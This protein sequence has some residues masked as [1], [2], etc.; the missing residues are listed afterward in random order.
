MRFRVALFIL[1]CSSLSSG[2]ASKAVPAFAPDPASVQR[3]GPG[4]RYP[5]AGWIV[6]H[7]EGK[8]YERGVQHGRLL[9]PEIA[10]YIRCF[11]A[12]QS[13]KSPADAWKAVRTLVNALFLRK[14]D[15]EYLEEMQGIADGAAAV[16]AKFE[17]R[18]IDLVDIVAVNTWAEVESLESAL[19]ATPN[20]LEGL[21]I[22]KAHSK[23]ASAEHCSAFAATGPATADGKVVFGHIT[24]F[25]LYPSRFYNVWL[26]IKPEKGHRVVM[27]SYPGGIQSGMD[28]YLNDA[29]LIV[30]ETTIDQ[31][32][33]DAQG[34]PLTSRIRK[35]MQYSD[36]IDKVV[37]TLKT[38]NNGLYSNEWLLADIKTNEIAMFELGTEKTKLWRSSKNEW[39][40]NTPGFYWGCNNGKDLHVRLETIKDLQGKPEDAVWAPS[41][42]D[43]TWMKFYQQYKGK[44]S[45]D[46]GRVAFT[47][48]PLCACTS[49]DAKITT[50]ALAGELKTLA[51]FGPPLG[52]PWLPTDTEKHDYPEVVPLIA[53]PWTLL[54][55]KSPPEPEKGFHIV[56]LPEKV[57][58]WQSLEDRLPAEHE[59]SSKPAWHG[60]IVPKTD[61]DTWLASAFA[62][63]EKIVAAEHAYLE[64][65]GD[66]KLLTSQKQHLTLM[67][68]GQRCAATQSFLLKPGAEK[69]FLE[70]DA[71]VRGET[72]KGVMKLS[73]LREFIGHKKFDEAMDSFG[74]KHGGKMVS[75]AEFKK[76]LE[77]ASG[78]DLTARF[79]LWDSAK[80]TPNLALKAT[81]KPG[82]PNTDGGMLGAV[83]P[84]F[85]VQGAISELPEEKSGLFPYPLEIVTKY[86]GSGT[87]APNSIIP[88][89]EGAFHT[90]QLQVLAE[91]LIGCPYEP[92][93]WGSQT[94]VHV[95]SFYHDLEDCLIVYG[96]L[97]DENTNKETAELLQE[98]IRKR[99]SNITVPIVADITVK[100]EHLRGHHLLLVG[101]PSTNQ[102]AK[103]MEKSFPVSFKSGSFT[104]DG[105]TYANS[106]SAAIASACNPGDKRYSMVMLAGLSSE[107]VYHTPAFLL[108]KGGHPGQLLVIPHSGKA[109]S[110]VIPPS[111]LRVDLSALPIEKK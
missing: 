33:F 80:T 69:D 61:E 73:L 50:A 83:M 71:W 32:R 4:W 103:E 18:A 36:S 74:K 34:T 45:A 44:I 90:T 70:R 42:R 104:V 87:L 94:D 39:F 14:F 51:M 9:A 19:T 56:D 99:G 16:G 22:P 66:D 64:L 59:H 76:H 63:Y 48:A 38:G 13:S 72:G 15:K 7:I 2:A 95:M 30:C 106:G 102:V 46:S 81:R 47:T 53:N 57:Q 86:Q 41:D 8:P 11:A 20:G 100:P 21:P 67:L 107:A 25:G 91:T 105:E 108:H 110:V 88:D 85:R 58:P 97:H 6:L 26:D 68:Y 5:Q 49:G 93:L 52:K 60:T 92:A 23:T 109:K 37:E 29:G 96:T 65:N 54:E 31:T 40:E 101:A 79:K 43:K 82:E 89:K 62:E 3:Y 75:V 28:Y 55:V 17:G 24:M 27:Q 78:S 77:S 35:A 1:L 10:A 12:Q 111:Q 98:M 84:Y